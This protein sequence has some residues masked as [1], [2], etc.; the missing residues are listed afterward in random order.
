M[1]A[2]SDLKRKLRPGQVYRR[3]DLARWS[4]SVDRHLRQLVEEGRLVK[5][6]AGLYRT[7]RKTRFGDAPAAPDKLVERFLKDDRFLM[8]SP[9]AYNGLG[10][11]ATQ[12]YNET[13]VYN[14]K[15]HG[16]HELDGRK[17]DFRQKPW[18][19]TRVTPEFLLVDLVD[20]LG[21]LAEDQDALASRAKERARQMD[22][23]AL[24]KAV[25][26]YGGQRA[27]RLLGPVLADD[28]HAVA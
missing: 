16:R 21:R 4:K 27:K 5:V 24:K 2:L 7:P 8:V 28:A 12:L 6:S 23:Q 9:N 10:V 25:R 13:I 22:R 1:T 19:P 3:A 15:R 11:G 18:F 20:N 14:A 17:Y 26:D